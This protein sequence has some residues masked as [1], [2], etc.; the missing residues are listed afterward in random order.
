MYNLYKEKCLEE[1][2]I[3]VKKSMYHHI[4]ATKFNLG[5][6][7]PKTDRC[8]LC[9]TVKIAK[10]NGTLQGRPELYLRPWANVIEAPLEGGLPQ[11]QRRV[12]GSSPGKLL[13]I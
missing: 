11:Q 2:K 9:K 6:H 1:D 10:N 3:P 7:I 5:F 4:F 13:D 12:R 8:D